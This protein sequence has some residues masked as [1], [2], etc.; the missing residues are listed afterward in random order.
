MTQIA[1]KKESKEN[2]FMLIILMFT[3]IITLSFAIIYI[4]NFK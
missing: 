3:M 4:G 1:N 2:L